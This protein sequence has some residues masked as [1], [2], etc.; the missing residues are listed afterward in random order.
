M[1]THLWNHDSFDVA[2][3][4]KSLHQGS[5]IRGQD[6]SHPI[7]RISA[8][9]KNGRSVGQVGHALVVT[10]FSFWPKDHVLSIHWLRA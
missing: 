8:S 1:K 5:S 7:E 10:P 9:V 2:H 3:F 6:H 4:A